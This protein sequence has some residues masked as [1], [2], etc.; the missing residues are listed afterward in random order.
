MLT[1]TIS[2]T[3]PRDG[4]PPRILRRTLPTP[5]I[6]DGLLKQAPGASTP[7]LAL[8]PPAIEPRILVA[9]ANSAQGLMIRRALEID[10]CEVE[11]CSGGAE[12]VH[13]LMESPPDLMLVNAPLRDGSAAALLRFMRARG[14]TAD[15]TCM[16]I[17]ATGESHDVASLYDAGADL[18]ITRPTE[19]DLLSRRVAAALS[20]R[21]VALAV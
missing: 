18:V 5:A 4:S 7:T 3:Q 10:G 17:V 13:M 1:R 15:L 8:A 12:A 20:R 19:L 11:T 6:A 9:G 2:T 16:V 21:P 14:E